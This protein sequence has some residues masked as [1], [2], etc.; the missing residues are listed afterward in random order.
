MKMLQINKLVAWMTGVFPK[1]EPDKA[2]AAVWALELPDI[3]ADEVME[4]VRTM[5]ARKPSPFPPGLF[6]IITAIKGTDG[7]PSPEEAWGIALKASDESASVLW[8]DEI[9]SAMRA[10]SEQLAGGDK[11]GARMAFKERYE[12]LVAEA[13]QRGT[14]VEWR[15]TLGFD[16]IQH[17]HVV[18]EGL[19][20]KLIE[21]DYARVLLPP[22]EVEEILGQT[23]VSIEGKVRIKQL[24]EG[25]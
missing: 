11:V 12:T 8:T 6:E 20:K 17:K 25:S 5:Q 21:P 10:Y 4:V 19:E 16:K 18:Q 23:R 15:V 3:E 2:V 1:W 7:R 24:T 14:P 22:G 13:R 9:A